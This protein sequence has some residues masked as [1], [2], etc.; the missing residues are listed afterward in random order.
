VHAPADDD[1]VFWVEDRPEGSIA[2][3]M[4]VMLLDLGLLN[5]S[6]AD[7]EVGLRRSPVAHA[8]VGERSSL[9]TALGL[10]PTPADEGEQRDVVWDALDA[11]PECLQSL[12]RV[13]PPHEVLV[14]DFRLLL[15][16][17]QKDGLP[18]PLHTNAK[19]I[20]AAVQAFLK[21]KDMMVFLHLHRESVHHMCADITSIAYIH[22]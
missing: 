12:M 19:Q 14:R 10:I 3:N 13:L 11:W 16:D 9:A 4:Y 18:K 7:I 17:D 1:D 20:Q 21:G 5:A 15:V 8:G 2:S 6:N 22:R